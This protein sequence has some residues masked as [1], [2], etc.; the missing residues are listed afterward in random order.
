MCRYV[1]ALSTELVV[2]CVL[3][4]NAELQLLQCS[5]FILSLPLHTRELTLKVSMFC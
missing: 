3:V 4:N 2:S 1:T 5:K